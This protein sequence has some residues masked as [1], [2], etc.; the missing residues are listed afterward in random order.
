M[1]LL[2][3]ERGTVS[4]DREQMIFFGIYI[5]SNFRLLFTICE[6]SNSLLEPMITLRLWPG[7]A[8]LVHGNT[9]YS[10]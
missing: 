8:K 2:T 1:E 9:E 6:R 5:P 3:L 7:I 10:S 4:A